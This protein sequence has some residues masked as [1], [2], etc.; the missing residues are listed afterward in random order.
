LHESSLSLSADH[1][2]NN[3]N[4]L[5]SQSTDD[6]DSVGRLGGWL[7]GSAACSSALVVVVVGGWMSSRVLFA[8]H[9][10]WL[11]DVPSIDRR[12]NAEKGIHRTGSFGKRR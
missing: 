12:R 4:Q 10:H 2:T 5:N 11:N 1:T 3:T 8:V 7:V 6:D 9:M